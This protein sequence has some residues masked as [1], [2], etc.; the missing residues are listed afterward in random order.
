MA[1]KDIK[2][3][4]LLLHTN[5]KLY[6]TCP[7]KPGKENTCSR[8]TGQPGAVPVLNQ[9]AAQAALQAGKA[10]GA[11]ILQAAFEK[12]LLP[13]GA[14]KAYRIVQKKVPF[15]KGGTLKAGEET[16][17][18]DS[19]SLAEEIHPEGCGSPLLILRFAQGI[20]QE[21]IPQVEKALRALGPVYGEASPADEISGICLPDTDILPVAP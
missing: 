19:I 17:V 7:A 6:C 20:G 12:E 14:P 9:A 11:E 10:F 1:A 3:L 18:L 21:Q 16:I 15:C 2:A 13:P 5:T 8:C 4:Q